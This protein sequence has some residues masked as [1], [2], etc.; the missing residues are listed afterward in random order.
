MVH[1]SVADVLAPDDRLIFLSHLP[2]DAAAL[3]DS[4]TLMLNEKQA[5]G[6][7]DD[8]FGEGYG[9]WFEAYNSG[10]AGVFSAPL[11][12]VLEGVLK[13]IPVRD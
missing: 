8:H 5:L 7:E 4:L 10:K 2:Y 3:M 13:H 1:I 9:M 6:R 12:D 11:S